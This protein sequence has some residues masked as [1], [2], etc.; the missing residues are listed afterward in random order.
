MGAS[1]NRRV[2]GVYRLFAVVL[3]A[4]LLVAPCLNVC[5][6]WSASDHARMACCVDKSQGE[7]D[8]CCASGEGRQNADVLAGLMVAALPVPAL[9]AD[10]IE[11]ILTASQ[12][13]TPQ[14]DSHDRILSNSD[15]YVLLSVFL[16]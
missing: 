11:S 16:I 4:A 6:G 14:W 9:D 15:R 10:Q 12:L 5:A 13:F 2:S 7:A 3:L 1:H 8:S